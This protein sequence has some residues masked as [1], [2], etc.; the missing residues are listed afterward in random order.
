MD[1]G[2]LRWPVIT[3][4]ADRML[5]LCTV[6]KNVREL[7]FMRSDTTRHRVVIAGWI[8][9]LCTLIASGV[10]ALATSR[11][12]WTNYWGGFVFAP[13]TIIGAVQFSSSS[14]VSRIG[15]ESA[16]KRAENRPQ[17]EDGKAVD[18]TLVL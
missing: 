3:Y 13:F 12:G 1:I 16:I 8:A 11:L 14:P 2:D 5:R 9:L 10:L 7:G 15:D 4:L 17:T 18:L 6:S